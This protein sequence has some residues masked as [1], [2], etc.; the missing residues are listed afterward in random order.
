MKKLIITIATIL[1]LATIMDTLLNASSR[2]RRGSI[3]RRGSRRYSTTPR[4][5]KK[6]SFSSL[7]RKKTPPAAQT[8]H[9]KEVTQK[10]E[11]SSEQ[12]N[13]AI[14]KVETSATPQEKEDAIKILK[15]KTDELLKNMKPIERTYTGDIVGYPSTQ[16]ELAK[17]Q[18]DDLAKQRAEITEEL[19]KKQGALD[20]ISD[21][22]SLWNFWRVS[23]KEEKDRELFD[24]L[25]KEVANLQAILTGL[26]EEIANQRV[27]AGKIWS[28]ARLSLVPAT[29]ILAAA[30]YAYGVPSIETIG[31]AV[32]TA[33]DI[34]TRAI[35]TATSY[36]PG[37]QT[38]QKYI[39]QDVIT[40]GEFMAKRVM[41][42]FA[43]RRVGTMI[44]RR[45]L[46]DPEAEAQA[47]AQAKQDLQDVEKYEGLEQI[48][49]QLSENP[50]ADPAKVAAIKQLIAQNR[51]KIRAIRKK[52][53][54]E[55]KRQARIKVQQGT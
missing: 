5:G 20:A 8:E 6:V 51:E 7:K 11:E 49:K 2:S 45:L 12:L 29:M 10:V 40:V 24:T 47:I 17:K 23:P 1:F 31:S 54:E 9:M 35:G 32:T 55:A 16:V 22:G 46:T 28:D 42:E 19:K 53:L 50:S 37:M 14:K 34:G 26:D 18:I 39:P 25:T 52:W 15:G 41:I 13:E 36:I 44:Y 33:K 27:I 3:R 38:A 30:G 43:L 48:D 4:T 21:K